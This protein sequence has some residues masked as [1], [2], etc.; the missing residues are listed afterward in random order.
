MFGSAYTKPCFEH[1]QALRTSVASAK[2]LLRFRA[3]HIKRYAMVAFSALSLFEASALPFCCPSH[4]F[5]FLA[6]FVCLACREVCLGFGP[7]VLLSS[8][9]LMLALH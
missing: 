7:A 9:A 4:L 5:V 2:Y 8:M 1:V 3:G 6:S